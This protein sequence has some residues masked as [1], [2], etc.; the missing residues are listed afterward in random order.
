M[1]RSYFHEKKKRQI[2]TYIT[3]KSSVTSAILK[4]PK[5]PKLQ[6]TYIAVD[7]SHD[8]L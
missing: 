5:A 3:N 4:Y 6:T 8:A 2:Y 1:Y 7:K